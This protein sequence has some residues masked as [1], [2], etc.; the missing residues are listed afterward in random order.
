MVCSVCL[1]M[2][3]VCFTAQV[4][5]KHTAQY[6]VC[7]DCGFLAAREPHWLED[8]YSRV[9]V[10]AD[11]G[12]IMRNISLASKVAGVLYWLLGERGQGRYLDAAGGYGMLTR[13]MRDVGF[14]FYWSD[15][16]CENLL[17]PGFEYRQELGAC[18]AVTAMEVLEHVTDPIAFIRET[19]AFSGADTVLFS[20]ELYQGTP[21]APGT[22]D[23]YAFSAGQHI[24]FYQRR[25][26]AV[27][28]DRLGLS[29]ASA[30]GLHIFSRGAVSDMLLHAVTSPL[31]AK[32]N[33]YWVRL[34]LGSK[35]VS[36]HR[37]LMDRG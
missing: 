8:A 10:R 14:D 27:M 31:V 23:Y 2:T 12:L 13:L 30:N 36:D 11:T 19:M 28:A 16:Y 33:K 5:G 25:T 9:I 18:Q 4:L 32:V 17:S 3:K 24:A 26:L 29:C 20:T 34:A 37:M 6:L 7:D 22:W 1:G 15:K 21:P 35:T